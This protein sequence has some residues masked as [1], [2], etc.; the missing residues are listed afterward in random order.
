M[1]RR[2]QCIGFITGMPISGDIRHY[3][4]IQP[5]LANRCSANGRDWCMTTQSGQLSVVAVEKSPMGDTDGIIHGID[6]KK[7]LCEFFQY[8]TVCGT[9][10]LHDCQTEWEKKGRTWPPW[11][12]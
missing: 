10:G 1:A 3:K 6:M 4:F 12:T 9:W 7:W 11:H 5:H 8:N 2:S